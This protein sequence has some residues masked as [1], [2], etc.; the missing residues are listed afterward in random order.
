MSPPVFL[1]DPGLLATV[2]PGGR[3]MVSGPEGRHGAAALRLR[4]GEL[5]D[6]VDAA[7]RR[8]AASVADV[9]RDTFT[10]C[11]EG[12]TDEPTPDPE[13]TVVQ[14]LV[15]GDRGEAAV[16]ML[17]EAGVDRIVPW[18]AR[19]CVV[20]WRGP[21]AERGQQRWRAVAS[22]A[23]KQSR[24]ARHPIVEPVATTAEVAARLGVAK[25]AL[26]LHES[27]AQRLAHVESPRAG[28]IVV[29]VGPEGGIDDDE[30]RRFEATGAIAVRLGG[31]VLR[32]STA[33]VAAASVVMAR[34]GRWG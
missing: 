9:D 20:Q 33:G 30:L 19:R 34:S 23:G 11:V 4:P 3:V 28:A 31:S 13:V 16:E 25:Q 10:V 12:V 18:A 2:H 17:T 7:G 21:R 22:A 27:A 6:L 1:L 29:V 15:K 5:V 24:R 8:V 32:A 26:I 14:A